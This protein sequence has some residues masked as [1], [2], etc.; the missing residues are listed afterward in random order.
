MDLI[1]LSAKLISIELRNQFGDIPSVMIPFE[2]K[3]LLKSQ[4]EFFQIFYNN[5]YLILE[6]NFSIVEDYL[7]VE[8]M[9]KVK[10]VSLKD[11]K[12]LEDSLISIGKSFTFNQNPVSILFGDTFFTKIDV[13]NF[14]SNFIFVS[15]VEDSSR[16]TIIKDGLIYD[17]KILVNE[18]PF[19]AITGFFNFENSSKFFYELENY[20]FYGSI[21]KL[22]LS[23]KIEVI[24]NT[25]W[26][27]LGHEDNLLKTK[28]NSTRYFNEIKV[29]FNRGI[30]TKFSTNTDKFRNEIN[31]YRSLP[32]KV[33]YI[34]PRILG[35][36]F[37]KSRSSLD[38][39]YYGYDT[40]HEKYLYGNF[41]IQKWETIFEVLFFSISELHK[42][43]KKIS[44]KKLYKNAYEMYILKPL[45]RLKKT[46]EDQ[47]FF[48]HLLSSPFV[49][50]KIIQF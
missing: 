41:S 42:Y 24:E 28:K 18:P 10:L 32:K 9:P 25:T 31:W 37:S 22:L 16:W 50:N 14:N 19:K 3:P 30:L 12:S 48:K 45:N 38:M 11:S 34:A 5:I 13:K 49:I 44:T 27:D 39:E 29:D 33:S 8:N 7:K 17:K 1:I 15:N 23:N 6:E 36:N 2:G 26:I 21:Q 35:W 43:K 4:Y 46:I 47:T 40:L 20:G